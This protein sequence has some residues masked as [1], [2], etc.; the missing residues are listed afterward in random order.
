MVGIAL[1]VAEQQ[2]WWPDGGVPRGG[3]ES[4]REMFLGVHIVA[5]HTFGEC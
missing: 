3:M 1:L 2:L 4:W 5:G